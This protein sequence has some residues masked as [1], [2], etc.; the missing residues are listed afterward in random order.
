MAASVKKM[1]G[2]AYLS[3]GRREMNVLAQD[4]ENH[5]DQL[6]LLPGAE[7]LPS[8]RQAGGQSTTGATGGI[9]AG[10]PPPLL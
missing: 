1:L 4:I 7:L 8:H 9:A 3:V 2:T 10:T 5:R 6:E